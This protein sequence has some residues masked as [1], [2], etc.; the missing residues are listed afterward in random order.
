MKLSHNGK[1]IYG[2]SAILVITVVYT[3]AATFNISDMLLNPWTNQNAGSPPLQRVCIPWILPMSHLIN[4]FHKESHM[5]QIFTS[6]THFT[7]PGYLNITASDNNTAI[8]KNGGDNK[9]AL[10]PDICKAKFL[11][12]ILWPY[13][14]SLDQIRGNLLNRHT[15]ESSNMEMYVNKHVDVYYRKIVWTE[16]GYFDLIKKHYPDI[17]TLH[18]NV[19][20]KLIEMIFPQTYY[21]RSSFSGRYVDTLK[22]PD[23]HINN[24]TVTFVTKRLHMLDELR[25]RRITHDSIDIGHI[26]VLPG[27]VVAKD[28][29]VLHADVHL[30]TGGCYSSSEN[31]TINSKELE[32]IKYYDE[33]F[34]ISQVWGYGYFHAT[35]ES[36]PRVVPYIRF[37]VRH[38]KIKVHVNSGDP[39]IKFIEKILHSLGINTSRIVF[40]MVVA[41]KILYMPIGTKCGNP[42]IFNIQLFSFYMKGSIELSSS[43]KEHSFFNSKLNIVLIERTG[44]R[45]FKRLVEIRKAMENL[46][47]NFNANL[48]VY[49]DRNL[50]SLNK[51]I[52][53]FHTTDVVIAP[54]GAGLCNIIFSKPG[55]YVLEVVWQPPNLCYAK[56]AEELGHRYVALRP[57]EG[58][59][60]DIAPEVLTHYASV[61]LK[62]IINQRG[63]TGGR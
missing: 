6:Y 31:I 23:N 11:E 51:A 7:I 14:S 17:A 63:Q 46:A 5:E 42:F 62:A 52:E 18:F 34:T 29:Q 12:V 47:I 4:I 40:G 26:H 43:M 36:I 16:K 3:I 1:I 58:H 27:G 56:L 30:G 32:Q 50:P 24:H 54:H 21:E 13:T 61:V 37:L 25:F 38:P 9:I 44:Q 10:M 60:S 33:V 57:G 2:F 48:N 22:D 45:R 28:G 59:P 55:T 20:T 19:S 35:V 49:S 53:I 39:T 41:K 15:P 8:D